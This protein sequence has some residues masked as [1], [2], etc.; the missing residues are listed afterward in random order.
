MRLQILPLE[1]VACPWPR[2]RCIDGVPVILA[3]FPMKTGHFDMQMQ[4][5]FVCLF[6]FVRVM[7]PWLGIEPPEA[8]QRGK[9]QVVGKELGNAAQAG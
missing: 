3:F 8:G 4:S 7:I 5:F 2:E 1:M 6:I 9:P